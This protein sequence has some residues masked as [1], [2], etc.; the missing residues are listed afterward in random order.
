MFNL[1][2]CDCQLEAAKLV[3]TDCNQF[4]I[5]IFEA[6]KLVATDCNQFSIIII[7]QV[8]NHFISLKSLFT[9]DL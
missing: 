7:I 2:H 1:N 8:Y 4:S 6:A 5:I 9:R 3:A